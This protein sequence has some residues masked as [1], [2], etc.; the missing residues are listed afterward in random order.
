MTTVSDVAESALGDGSTLSFGRLS[1]LQ[2]GDEFVVGDPERSV[3]L[4]VPE[5]GVVALR[6]LAAGRTVAEASEAAGRHMGT[7]VNVLE[8]AEGLLSTGLVIAVDGRTTSTSA[9]VEP[10]RWI[11]AVRPEHA[12]PF[13][14]VYA[15]IIYA[16]FAAS[17][18]LLFALEPT[19]WPT[20]E[21][22]YFY[23]DPALCIVT[24][25]LLG[26]T[27][28]ACHELCHWLAARAA[29]IAARFNV[30]RRFFF[31]VFETDLSQL[32][33]LP[34]RQRFAPLLAGMAFDTVILAPCLGLRVAWS[35][36][37][38]DLPALAV[39]LLGVVVLLKVVG[40]C[41]QFLVFMRTDLYAVLVTAL[42][43][44]NLSRVSRFALKEKFIALPADETHELEEAHPRDR[45]AAA[46]YAPLYLV[47]LAGALYFFAVYFVPS[48]VVLGGWMF[49]SLSG[50]PVGSG[51]FWEALAIGLVT[52]TQALSPLLIAL[53]DAA[54]RRRH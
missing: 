23:P 9:V 54:R 15:W 18:V 25:T 26:M 3:F 20:F 5:V 46:L 30:S 48:T 4:A 45:R 42:G 29:G 17:T 39:R 13:F 14:S 52:A 8:F 43:C 33:T 2:E 27:F 31:L 16:A 24:V 12:R 22:A 47:G 40:L 38:L 21:D 7:D 53:R 1:V 36:G 32:W 44:R 6:E 35:H 50:A 11:D 49:L 34:R 41:F 10:V 28:A 37:L 51:P 19:F